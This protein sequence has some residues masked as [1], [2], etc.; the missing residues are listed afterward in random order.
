MTV[1]EVKVM[2]LEQEYYVIITAI[3]LW[4]LRG[5]QFQLVLFYRGFYHTE[6]NTTYRFVTF[7]T[8]LFIRMCVP[9]RINLDTWFIYVGH[10]IEI[11]DEDYILFI[12]LSVSEYNKKLFLNIL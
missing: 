6:K 10:P 8:M 9:E 11:C 4:L 5:G 1:E 7:T 12:S 2:V 3:D